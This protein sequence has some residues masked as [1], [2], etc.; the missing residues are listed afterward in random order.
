VL[1]L[2]EASVTAFG[3][4]RGAFPLDFVSPFVVLQVFAIVIVVASLKQHSHRAVRYLAEIT[5]FVYIIHPFVTEYFT[6]FTTLPDRV[7]TVFLHFSLS[8]GLSWILGWSLCHVF[9]WRSK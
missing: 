9:K 2:Y 1:L 8:V 4:R 6:G 3:F 5:P 7:S